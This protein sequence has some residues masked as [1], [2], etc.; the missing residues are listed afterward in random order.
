MV[1]MRW[2]ILVLL[3]KTKVCCF[4]KGQNSSLPKRSGCSSNKF[5]DPSEL[6]RT[7]PRSLCL[8]SSHVLLW[9]YHKGLCTSPC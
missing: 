7:G 2:G 5:Q 3:M 9:F 4:L 8:L 6:P 1:L